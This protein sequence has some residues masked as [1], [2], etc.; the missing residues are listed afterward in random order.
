MTNLIFAYAALHATKA[1]QLH[2]PRLLWLI[3]SLCAR[4]GGQGVGGW[5]SVER[6]IFMY[7]ALC[8]HGT[9]ALDW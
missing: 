5:Q 9:T 2:L 7:K 3:L 1:D 4:G 8:V 6:A